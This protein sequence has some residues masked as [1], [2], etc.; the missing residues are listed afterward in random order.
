MNINEDYNITTE[1]VN[2]AIQAIDNQL[3]IAREGWIDAPVEKKAKWMHKINALLE[4][5]IDLMMLRN[6]CGGE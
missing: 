1:N 5:R 6:F 3:S 4:N 2:E